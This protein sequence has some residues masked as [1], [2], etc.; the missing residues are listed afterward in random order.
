M[1]NNAY[2]RLLNEWT[3]NYR[4]NDVLIAYCEEHNIDR[5]ADYIP[6]ETLKE[7]R[8][9]C[10][11]HGVWLRDCVEGDLYVEVMP[12]GGYENDYSTIAKEL[13]ALREGVLA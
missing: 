12:F 1:T 4:I 2:H 6:V 11:K 3:A 9:Y 8:S 5:Y 10:K 13:R 7:I